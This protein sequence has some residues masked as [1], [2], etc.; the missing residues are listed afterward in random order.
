MNRFICI[1]GHFY[2]PPRE[3][4][5]LEAI[6]RQESAYPYH[7]WN[8]RI[9]SECYEANTAARILDG[10]GR[11]VDIVNNYSKISFNLGPTLMTWLR[12]QSHP[13][14]EAIVRADRESQKRFSG[15]G[16]ALAQPYNHM[17]M[18]LSNRRDK[19][20]QVLWGIRDFESH[21][22]R[23]P[24]G[25]WLPET[26]VDIETL[27]VLSEAGVKFTILAP[28]QIRRVRA[29]GG[30]AWKDVVGA[31]I[32]P[33]RP[34]LVRLPSQRSICVFVYDGPISRAVAFE[35]LLD[36]GEYLANRLINALDERDISPQI[37]N[38]A[39][40]GETYGHHHRFGEMA[41]AYALRIIE[42]NPN[43]Q[44]TNYGEFLEKFPPG[45]EIEIIEDTAWSCAHGIERWRSDCGCNSGG[46]PGW[47]QGWRAPLR[48]AFDWL[49]D[50]ISGAYERE[51]KRF[52]KDPWS[53]RDD[54]IDVIS[55]RSTA[56]ID[57]FITRHVGLPLEPSDRVL[58]LKLLEQQ[59]NAMLMYT[60]CGWFFDDL[61]GI[62]TVQV[63]QYAA[64]A[65]QL[66]QEL[67]GDHLESE[68]LNRLERA[69]SNLPEFGTGRQ[70]YEKQVRPGI[71][72]LKK[73]AAHFILS[74]L[75]A[76]PW[77]KKNVYCYKVEPD[78]YRITESGKAKL[79]L[80]SGTITST[81]TE[82]S[83]R[84]SFTG[85]HLG[86]HN[87]NAG[88]GRYLEKS[89]FEA[90]LAQMTGALERGELTEL[91]RLIDKQYGPDVYS[92]RILFRDEQR[93]IMRKILESTLEE[94]EEEYRQLH[95]RLAPLAR[96][97]ADLGMQPPRAFQVVGEF[98]VNTNLVGALREERI[99]LDRLQNLL[100]QAQSEKVR[101]DEPRLGHAVKEALEDKAERLKS[102]PSDP[103]LLARLDEAAGVL[104]KLPFGVD[105]TKVQNIYF[106]MLKSVFPQ[107]V[108][109]A[110]LG[111]PAA[112]EWTNRFVA[113]GEKLSIRID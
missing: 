64:R 65:V 14:Y 107:R 80:G 53:A 60:S 56:S 84:L 25:M 76:P 113:L 45:H 11:I 104:T 31:R 112:I 23:R 109:E 46:K 110:E 55:Q 59:R 108:R 41:L 97:L 54:Y 90:L 37:V 85:I 74:S 88:V 95:D 66:G 4:P 58:M 35:K 68:F 17:I 18:P 24:E 26:A 27:E 91:I 83:Q 16:S 71:V 98:V 2:Q 8:E 6:E 72:D 63:I 33:R 9:T 79:G 100:R 67:F 103:E 102:L 50:E 48:A 21:Y 13:V 92:L 40:D 89:D 38:I 105:V 12:E 52:V 78:F 111:N 93:R 70:I 101:L 44:L 20:T 73:V 75:F 99:D 1:H 30:R 34:Y 3:S 81:I 61:A 51:M 94:V 57:R 62:E 82:E 5:W 39:S 36:R 7:D 28:H 69:H 22:N 43:I 96:F 15:H 87:L 77:E 10:Q 19:V 49:R 29:I 32:D 86:D 47:R 42:T 106:E